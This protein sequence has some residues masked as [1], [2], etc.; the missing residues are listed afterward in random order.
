MTG[1]LVAWRVRLEDFDWCIIFAATAAKAK[2]IAVRGWREAGYG[3]DGRWPTSLTVRRAD[4]YDSHPHK[5]HP[6]IAYNEL[7]MGLSC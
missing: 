5:S 2:W 4:H 3:A 6:N 1:D 7:Y